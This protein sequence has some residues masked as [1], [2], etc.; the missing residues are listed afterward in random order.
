MGDAEDPF[1]V[2][3]HE[4]GLPGGGDPAEDDD[5]AR[6]DEVPKIRRSVA[7][8]GLPV[9]EE[10]ARSLEGST[11]L[12]ELVGRVGAVAE[13]LAGRHP[14][15]VGSHVL[16]PADDPAVEGRDESETPGETDEAGADDEAV[17][18]APE[19]VDAAPSAR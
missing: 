1:G 15:G 2:G 7:Q 9:K 19:I 6:V 3:A 11:E 4:D 14:L 10:P 13:R 18:E 16:D 12:A 5:G 17:D 8:P